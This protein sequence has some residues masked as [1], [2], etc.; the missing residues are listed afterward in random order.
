MPWQQVLDIILEAKGLDKREQGSVVMIA[1]KEELARNE[2]QELEAK[3]KE[4]EL[5]SLAL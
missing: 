5:S 4:E 3:R 2:R 1:P